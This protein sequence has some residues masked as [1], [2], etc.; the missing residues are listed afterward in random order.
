VR[1]ALVGLGHVAEAQLQA[2]T[3]LDGWV[4]AG[5]ADVDAG[6]RRLLSPEVPFFE[7]V[8]ALLAEV[9]AD[10]VLVSTPTP[11]HHAVGMQVLASGRHLLLEKPC[12]GSDAEFEALQG[13]A[14]ERGCFLHVALHSL[15][16]RDLRWF[17]ARRPEFPPGAPDSIHCRFFDPYC[18]NGRLQPSARALGG[19]WQDSGINALAVAATL[20][21][22]A[23]LRLQRARLDDSVDGCH[24]VCASVEFAVCDGRSRVTIDTSWVENVDSKTT[25]LTWKAASTEVLLDHSRERVRV[26]RDGVAEAWVELAGEQPRLVNHYIGV[27][28]DVRDALSRGRS[29]IAFARAIHEL[30]F[31]AA[32]EGEGEGE[33]RGTPWH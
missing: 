17:L 10:L 12:C 29:N 13:L 11:T 27:F 2:L 25:M 1:L 15:H 26:V 8:D 28:D 4:L 3:L 23:S 5:A 24:D 32:R 21:E 31:V 16:A 33:A 20:V 18:S 30:L 19:S 22:A 6:R 7:S 14:A 9:D